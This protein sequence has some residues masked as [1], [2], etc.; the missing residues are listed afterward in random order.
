MKYPK[1]SNK[2]KCSDCKTPFEDFLSPPVSQ[3]TFQGR[4][5]TMKD[6][7]GLFFSSGRC[8]NCQLKK[9]AE[10]VSAL[11]FSNT[12]ITNPADVPAI[13]REEQHLINLKNVL[14]G[15]AFD[16]ATVDYYS[17]ALRE[18]YPTL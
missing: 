11:R 7:I 10:D 8:T 9:N 12:N 16:K 13:H 1:E 5:M 3:R 17:N 14:N 4:T 2:P 18:F 15:A 6:A